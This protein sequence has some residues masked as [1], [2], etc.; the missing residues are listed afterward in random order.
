MNGHRDAGNGDALSVRGP[1]VCQRITT[2]V[3]RLSKTPTRIPDRA[4]A[5]AAWSMAFMAPRYGAA[6][7]R[8]VRPRRQSLSVR[9]YL[10]AA[11]P[12]RPERH[13]KLD[14]RRGRD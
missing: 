9:S 10:L 14:W 4:A 6:V 12:L 8:N 5:R 7:T 11:G 3:F 2:R 13:S 1:V